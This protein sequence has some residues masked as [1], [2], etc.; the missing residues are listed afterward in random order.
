MTTHNIYIYVKS[1]YSYVCHLQQETGGP[2]QH[3][4][5]PIQS[6][7]NLDSNRG[8]VPPLPVGLRHPRY[9]RFN[10][11]G[12]AVVLGLPSPVETV[13]KF[14]RFQPVKSCIPPELKEPH[15]NKP[16][17]AQIQVMTSLP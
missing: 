4:T 7:S 16:Q 11:E 2:L 13:K 1:L 14:L 9:E 15:P 12:L 5:H 17:A 8:Y 6:V 3:P 10:W